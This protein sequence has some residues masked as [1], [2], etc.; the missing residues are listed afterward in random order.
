MADENKTIGII[1]IDADGKA[2]AREPVFVNLSSYKNS[3]YLDLRKFYEKD[4]KWLPGTK[5]IT[6]HAQQFT[7]LLKILNEHRE[8]ILDWTSGG[9]KT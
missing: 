1:G 2:S 8:E 3:R 9:S 4:G 7:E 5:G 6:L